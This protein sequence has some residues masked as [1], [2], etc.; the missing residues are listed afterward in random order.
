MSSLLDELQSRVSTA[1]EHISNTRRLIDVVGAVA[2]GAGI[3]WAIWRAL[4]KREEQVPAAGEEE[5][6]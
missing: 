2:M 4:R 3:V 5:T 1:E 6:S